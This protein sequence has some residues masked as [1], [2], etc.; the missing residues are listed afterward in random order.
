MPIYQFGTFDAENDEVY[1][2]VEAY[3]SGRVLVDK[4]R[5]EWPALLAQAHRQYGTG[6]SELIARV[7]YL[8]CVMHFPLYGTT[9]FSVTYRG[10]WAYGNKLILG[11]NCEG[12]ALIKPDDKFVM[13]EYR[14]ADIESILVD[15]SDDFLTLTL[16]Q[17]LPDAH[18]CLVFETKEKEEIASLMVSYCPALSYWLTD[19]DR[20]AKKIKSVSHEDK[21]RRFQNVVNCRRQII[22]SGLLRKPAEDMGSFLRSTLRRLNK[23][24]AE[25][26]RNVAGG[27][28]HYKGFNH[29]EWAFTR[30]PLAQALTRMVEVDEKAAVENFR[31]ILTYAG[32]VQPENGRQ[33][34]EEELIPLAQTILERSMKKECLF[35]ELFLQLIK[36]TTDHPEVNSRVN[37]RHWALL[38]LVC[39]IAL[40]QDKI[41]RKYLV[42]HLKLCAADVVSE[43]GKFARFAEKASYLAAICNHF[44]AF[45]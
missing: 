4:R 28:D 5:E 10:Y 6:K 23:Q 30:Y 37:L 18:K 35:N 32:L 12:V 8:S 29:S 26:L 43:E 19:L 42:A 21:V 41:I 36:Q 45:N 34:S 11:V 13:Y 27:G 44:L 7:W 20:P 16:L 3:L 40:P 15:P 2:N 31:L 25:K 22:D 38:T 1:K 9:M 14:F 33:S 24:K 39:S 17:S